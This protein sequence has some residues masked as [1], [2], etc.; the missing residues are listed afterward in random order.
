M[1]KKKQK[2]SIKKTKIASISNSKEIYF[3]VGGNKEQTETSCA[4]PTPTT[5]GAGSL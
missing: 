1:K 2:L 3:I 5:R 4:C